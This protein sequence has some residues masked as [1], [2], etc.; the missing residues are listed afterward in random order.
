MTATEMKQLLLLKFDGLFELSAPAYSDAQLSAVLNNA[1]RR[2]LR[3]VDSPNPQKQYGGFDYT[4]RVSK[5]IS[6]LLVTVNPT[7]STSYTA[8]YPNGV[9][10]DLPSTCWYIKSERAVVNSNVVAV[11]RVTHDFY[12]ANIK[13]NFKNPNEEEI[14]RVDSGESV[15]ELI[16]ATGSTPSSYTIIYTKELDDINI[17]AGDDCELHEDLHD[18]IVD[19]AFKIMTGA[20]NPELYN[21]ANNEA[22]NN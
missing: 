13:N 2:I 3:D 7:A 9:G 12:N 16:A 5:Y 11:K 1:Q 17:T 15:V 6:P 14:W 20:A 21:I 22:N 4:E 19:E 8:F 10:Y 18:D